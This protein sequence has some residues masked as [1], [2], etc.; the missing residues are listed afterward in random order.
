M[1]KNKLFLFA[2]L[3]LLSNATANALPQSSG[4]ASK[5]APSKAEQALLA[6]YLAELQSKIKSEWFPPKGSENESITAHFKVL[7]D[8]AVS[9]LRLTS[10]G[11]VPE[12]ALQA[13]MHAVAKASPFPSLPTGAPAKGIDVE[14]TFNYNVI[15]KGQTIP[16]RQ[17][18][19]NSAA[20]QVGANCND[21][22]AGTYLD[23]LAKDL[24]RAC[25]DVPMNSQSTMETA[26]SLSSAGSLQGTSI[27]KSSGDDAVDASLLKRIVMLS[28]FP[29]LPQG[30]NNPTIISLVFR[31]VDQQQQRQFPSVPQNSSAVEI[32]NEGVSLLKQKQ[33][34]AA[35]DKLTQAI[36]IDP[37]CEVAKQNMAIAYNNWGLT[38]PAGP[39]IHA[40]RRAIFVEP[41]SRCAQD[42][43]SMSLANM[44]KAAQTYEDHVKLAEENLRASNFVD[45]FVEYQEALKLKQDPDISSKLDALRTSAFMQFTTQ[46]LNGT[47][48]KPAAISTGTHP[49]SAAEIAQAAQKVAAKLKAYAEQGKIDPSRAQS[50]A[51]ADLEVGAAAGIEQG[52]HGNCWFESSLAA[53]AR[54]PQGQQLISNMIV[55]NTDGSYTVTFAGEQKNPVVVSE[56]DI[57]R[58]NIKDA[59]H[60]ARIIEAAQIQLYPS[61]SRESVTGSSQIPAITRGLSLITGKPTSFIEFKTC[62]RENILSMLSACNDGTHVLVASSREVEDASKQFVVPNHGF[63]IL[64]YNPQ[65]QFVILRNP[66]GNNG[67]TAARARFP[68]LPHVGKERDGVCDLGG[69]LLRVRLD[70]F[71]YLYRNMAI[72]SI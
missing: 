48:T 25:Q 59:S 68:N 22:I 40:F 41:D 50:E 32:N 39:A 21:N 72:S 13:A 37:N 66:W 30:A 8:G 27:K 2:M 20:I 65:E 34:Q 28:P 55:T 61:N 44:Q 53:V 31:A 64:S 16:G 60:W 4:T 7:S 43:L 38:L 17:L 52:A 12:A 42:N 57:Q 11:N 3:T 56:D 47:D 70:A 9:N 10:S 54:F 24:Q 29:S 6:P 35:I 5:D 58:L 19:A 26:I 36:S 62:T 15:R 45:A 14:F 49:F 1:P 23:D 46:K 51:N 67:H 71:C 18:Q 63:T 33:F 69:G